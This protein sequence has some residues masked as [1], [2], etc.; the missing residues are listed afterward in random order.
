MSRCCRA[1]AGSRFR[2]RHFLV[3]SP[4]A[5]DLISSVIVE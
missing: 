5:Y 4:E 1:S 3:P 2:T